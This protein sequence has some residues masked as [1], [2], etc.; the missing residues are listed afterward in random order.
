MQSQ[1]QASAQ[2]LDQ[3]DLWKE[4]QDFHQIKADSAQRLVRLW[5]REVVT[6]L[7][8]L[9]AAL[10]RAAAVALEAEGMA[11]GLRTPESSKIFHAAGKAVEQKYYCLTVSRARLKEAQEHLKLTESRLNTVKH[12]RAVI[13]EEHTVSTDGVSPSKTLVILPEVQLEPD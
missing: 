7:Q 10:Q 1:K 5:H 6:D 9:N 3:S 4:Y 11:H 12:Q 8:H 2:C 13:P